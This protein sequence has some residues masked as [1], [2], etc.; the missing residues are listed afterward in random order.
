MKRYRLLRDNKESGPFVLGELKSLGL[1]E[2]DLVWVEEEST[3]WNYPADV[4]ELKLMVRKRPKPAVVNNRKPLQQQPVAVSE[5]LFAPE[6]AEALSNDYFSQT[7]ERIEFKARPKKFNLANVTANLFGMGVLLI[8]VMM[9]AFVVKK[10]ID[11]FEFEPMVASAN[12]VEIKNELLPVSTGSYAA[13]AAD[14]ATNQL[15][16]PAA[17]ATADSIRTTLA[18]SKKQATDF[19]VKTAS[20]VE[21]TEAQKTDVVLVKNTEQESTEVTEASEQKTESTEETEA[22]KKAPSL[23]LSANNYK[24][25][26]FGGISGLEIT[27][28]NP[29][30]TP[31]SK[32]TV[33]VEFLKPN[34]NVVKTETLLVEN[35]SAGGAKT[36]SVPSSS[37]GVNVRYKIVGVNG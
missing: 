19:V 37:R 8:G 31:V 18:E 14:A 34:G 6:S 36:I 12:A 28:N 10:V 1:Y 3:C 4:P 21:Q 9:G 22:P 30:S 25:G 5:D 20:P 35:I 27:V 29:S 2:S 32:A 13:K 7:K 23:A 26:V 33:Q 15:E 17:V 16:N 11:H 24:V